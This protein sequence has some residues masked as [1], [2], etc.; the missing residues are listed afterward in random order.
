[1]LCCAVLCCTHCTVLSGPILMYALSFHF[2]K[3]HALQC[4]VLSFPL[5]F[6][7]PCAVLSFH[8]LS[9]A[10][11]LSSPHLPC[12][13]TLCH[14]LPCCAMLDLPVLSVCMLSVSGGKV[15]S[16]AVVYVCMPGRWPTRRALSVSH[17]ACQR[18]NID[19]PKHKHRQTRAQTPSDLC[20]NIGLS[21]PT[22][23][24]AYDE[25]R[26]GAV[27]PMPCQR[28]CAWWGSDAVRRGLASARATQATTH[29]CRLR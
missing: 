21:A 29:W 3:C 26:I 18:T 20:T 5:L 13:F 24:D 4:R 1:M 19:R 17:S 8:A 10:C 11:H 9:C 27:S 12:C 28:Y 22:R 7:H 14:V 23:R 16:A 25:H 2:T 6:C 15:A